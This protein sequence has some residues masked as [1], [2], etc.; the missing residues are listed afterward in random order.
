MKKNLL[1][2]I[3]IVFFLKIVMDDLNWRLAVALLQHK[4]C[5][6]K[7]DYVWKKNEILPHQKS[8]FF[9]G[10]KVVDLTLDIWPSRKSHKRFITEYIPNVRFI[11][12]L[13]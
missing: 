13:T 11:I 4:Y 5:A 8:K 6:E 2:T 9:I 7:D 3:Y 1:G 10:S 12:S